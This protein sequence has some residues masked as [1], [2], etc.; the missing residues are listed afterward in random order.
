MGQHKK[1]AWKHAASALRAHVS[2]TDA[3]AQSLYGSPLF[4]AKLDERQV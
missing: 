4:A 1:M 3:L 2:A